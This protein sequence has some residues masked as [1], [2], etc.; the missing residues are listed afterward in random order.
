MIDRILLAI[1]QIF[2]AGIAI[3]AFSLFIRA[4]SFNLR[5]RVS[6]SFAIIL[7]CI[8]VVFSGEAI[9]ASVISPETITLWL[10]FQWIGII[11]FPP[12]FVHFSDALMETTGKPSRGRRR[13]LVRI[14]YTL[15]TAFLVFLPGELLVGPVVVGQG[16]VP[17]LAHTPLSVA[18]TVFYVL[19]SL[20]A[21]WTIWRAYRRT[22]LSHSQRRMR[23][24]MTGAFFLVI[25]TYPYLQIGSGFAYTHPTL[26][27]ALALIGNLFVFI[28]LV[29][30]AYAVAYFGIV[31]PDR[32]VKSRLAKW[33]FRGPV[34]VFIVLFLM[35]AARQAGNLFGSPYTVSIP[36][37]TVTTVL[38]M[39]HMATLVSPFIERWFFQGG[40]RQDIQLL[41]EVSDRLITTS[42]L[43]EYLEAVLASVCD[44]FQVSSAFIAVLGEGSIENVIHV[45]PQNM[46][47]RI[48][49]DEMLLER[50]SN[51]RQAVFAWGDFWLFPLYS[52][53]H[54]EM[55]GLL[56]VPRRDDYNLE[57]SLSQ[58]LGIYG[59][60]AVMVLEDRQLQRQVFQALE[61]LNP[62]MSMIQQMRAATRYDQRDIG[63]QIE[64]DSRPKDLVDW[65]KDAL[66]HYWGGPK[67]TESPLL[68]LQVVQ[69]AMSDH[70]DNPANALRA[71]LKQG[72]DSVKPEGERRFTAEW[73]LYNILELKFM[74]GR[75]VREIA[76][77]LAM[78]EADLYRKQRVAI[79]E[80]AKA[81][82]EMELDVRAQEDGG[83]L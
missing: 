51:G 56:G 27:I 82:V 6:R 10:R 75:K 46:M 59:Q 33:L 69:K 43:R 73:I 67:L 72:I 61:T 24:L 25:G 60:R 15:S 30:M 22:R 12:A 11:F 57:D 58:T 63:E 71:I 80:V 52:T 74:Q 17:H 48:G 50:A 40:D 36:I 1:N 29:L 14:L 64:M 13:R 81:L 77:R 68:Q 8:M 39:E 28:N 9:A 41:Q 49:L 55:L 34:T 66:R 62:K 35:T 42:D 3:T 78:S 47:D 37:I 44:K 54:G 32:L 20:F 2:E 26:F 79:E 16:P 31:W 19:A 70:E 5:D 53:Q 45:G 23:Y 76:M 83:S 7:A 38:F 21:G 4:L 65:V 18:F